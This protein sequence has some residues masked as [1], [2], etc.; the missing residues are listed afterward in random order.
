M[1]PAGED[2]SRL[3][4]MCGSGLHICAVQVDSQVP[5]VGVLSG[6][7]PNFEGQCRA[8]TIS[9]PAVKGIRG[10]R[11]ERGKHQARKY[12][13]ST[14]ETQ[15]KYTNMDSIIKTSSRRQ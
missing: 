6:G 13:H 8:S 2:Y 12:P 9:E 7:S 3:R 5:V 1:R 15:N 11:H 4:V 10:P 14:H